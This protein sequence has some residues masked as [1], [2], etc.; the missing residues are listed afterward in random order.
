MNGEARPMP[1]RPSGPGTT[2]GD[3]A[4]VGK[5]ASR[6]IGDLAIVGRALGGFARAVVDHDRRQELSHRLLEFQLYDS[7][8]SATAAARKRF[9]TRAPDIV[10]FPLLLT[11][12]N[13]LY[14]LEQGEL[15]C[16]LAVRCFGLARHEGT[17]FLGA[18]AGIHSFVLSARIAGGEH[19][20]RLRDV[21]VLARYETRYQNERI[22]QI[23]F[24][25]RT[26]LVHCANCR[27]NSL[28]AVDTGGRGIVDEKLLF[29]DGNGNP[30]HTDQNHI[31][32]VTVNGDTLLFAAHTADTNAGALGFV[33]NDVV[34]AYRYPARGVH[35]V[36]I[37]DDGVM[38]T[39]SFRTAIRFR[40]EEYLSQSIDSKDR[41]L[42]LRGLAMCGST[43]VVGFSSFAEWR[44]QRSGNSGGGLIVFHGEKLA[45][46]IEGPFGQVH[47]VLPADGIRTDAC[48]GARTV[49]ELDAMFLRDVG[50]LLSEGPVRRAKRRPS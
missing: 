41:R 9:V 7:F 15:H 46:L 23:A 19:I 37:H 5:T 29:A 50:P 22:H 10:P 13:G 28:L 40:G 36:V 38:F 24:D 1:A 14:L 30:L 3:V 18:T 39:D 8:V 2:I 35:D 11:T 31:N 25:P 48:G 21:E 20:E 17:V 44:A 6:L 12:N 4:V 27:G 32:S 34:R 42:V 33:A 43:L 26:N 16:L 49:A 45:G 47:D